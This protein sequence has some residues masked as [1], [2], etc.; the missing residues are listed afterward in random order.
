MIS[1]L[2]ELWIEYATYHLCFEAMV[3]VVWSLSRV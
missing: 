2:V 3:V 1:N